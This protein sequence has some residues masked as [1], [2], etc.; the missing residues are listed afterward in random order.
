MIIKN[1]SIVAIPNL[2]VKVHFLSLL[3]SEFNVTATTLKVRV[4]EA[5]P[6]LSPHTLNLGW[7]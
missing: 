6:I 3:T 2:G 5:V 7:L 1:R 4:G